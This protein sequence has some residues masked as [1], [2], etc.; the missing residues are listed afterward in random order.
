[1]IFGKTMT[2]NHWGDIKCRNLAT[3]DSCEVK[4]TGVTGMFLKKKDMAKIHGHVYAAGSKIPSYRINGSWLTNIS[5]SKYMEDIEEYGPETRIYQQYIVKGDDD[6][7]W[8]EVYRYSELSMALNQ[9]TP[10]VAKQLPPTDARF[11]PDMRLME[12]GDGDGSTA[13]KLRLEQ[14]Q[15]ERRKLLGYEP[16]PVYFTKEFID[17]K[18]GTFWYKFGSPRNYFED[19]EKQDWGHLPRYFD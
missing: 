19:R 16:P 3:G 13:E 14:E 2:F 11:R 12:N 18:K 10:E 6:T 8:D 15:R 5:V 1:M 4:M 9:L 7:D 17:E